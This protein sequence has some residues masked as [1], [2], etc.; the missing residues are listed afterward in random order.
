MSGRLAGAI[1]VGIFAAG[2]LVLGDRPPLDS[3][4]SDLASW[5]ESEQT[6]IQITCLLNGVSAALLVWF[7]ASVSSAARNAA[8]TLALAGGLGFMTLFL[9]D[10]TA[11]AVG[12]LRPVNDGDLAAA[13]VD[14]ELLA[15]GMAAPLVATM[16]FA[17]GASGVW[18]PAF[19]RLAHVAG[20]LY[21]LR[22]A[23]LLTVDG[24][25][26]ADGPLGLYVPVVAVS[27]WTFAASVA[28]SRRA[29]SPA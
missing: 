14:F 19:S 23:T 21:L 25:F 28:F 18:G 12:A 11:L 26:A 17:L 15:M 27:A 9:A 24:P 4:G 10:N 7:L 16:L 8:G 3:P 6:R 1:A 22:A 2:G 20:V 13:L 5:F 29:P